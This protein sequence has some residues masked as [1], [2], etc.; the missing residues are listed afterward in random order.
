MSKFH[1]VFLFGSAATN[2]CYRTI[3]LEYIDKGVIVVTY[4]MF[5]YSLNYKNELRFSV[6]A[7]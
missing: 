1:S 6:E 3:S 2:K 7:L 5:N 4:G